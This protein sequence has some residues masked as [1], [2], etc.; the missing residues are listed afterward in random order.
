MIQSGEN[1]EPSNV[2]HANVGRG[3]FDEGD[4]RII[5]TI[6]IKEPAKT[7]NKKKKMTMGSVKIT[8]KG[9]KGVISGSK[10]SRG[11]RFITKPIT[12]TRNHTAA[13]TIET[14]V[15][16]ITAESSTARGF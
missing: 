3:M 4:R 10:T 16:R 8:A 7:K 5:S 14:C 11:K 6:I 15:R 13:K 9:I 1:A 12:R 2:G